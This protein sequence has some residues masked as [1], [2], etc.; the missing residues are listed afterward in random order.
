MAQNATLY[1][2]HLS[3]ADMDKHY[4]ADHALTVVQHP[5]EHYERMM[6][7]LMAFIFHAQQEPKFTRGLSE[8]SEPEIWK[9][10]LDDRVSLWVDIGLPDVK[11]IQKAAKRGPEVAVYQYGSQGADKW[12]DQNKRALA[13]HKNVSVYVI[14]AEAGDQLASLIERR[15]SISVTVQDGEM[16]L[17]LGHQSVQVVREQRIASL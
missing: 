14:N 2:I 4:Y 3:I 15:M 11:R 17:S 8:E 13:A 16:L 6:L 7:R 9:V 12:W 1:N 10:E 5:S